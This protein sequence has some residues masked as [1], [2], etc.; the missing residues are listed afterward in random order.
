ME[1]PNWFK[2]T[3]SQN[4]GNFNHAIHKGSL[5]LTV[6]HIMSPYLYNSFIF[7]LFSKIFQE[8]KEYLQVEGL[9][10]LASTFM[11]LFHVL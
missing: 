7:L 2:G 5:V 4:F 1:L 3:F 6:A 10:A 9:L 8:A 11:Q